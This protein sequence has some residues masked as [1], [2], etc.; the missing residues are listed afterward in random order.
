MTLCYFSYLLISEVPHTNC[1][2]CECGNLNTNSLPCECG[3][4]M[5]LQDSWWLV[6]SYCCTNLTCGYNLQTAGVSH[7]GGYTMNCVWWYAPQMAESRGA[8]HKHSTSC[9][10]TLTWHMKQ[11]NALHN[12]VTMHESCPVQR[13]GAK[14]LTEWALHHQGTVGGKWI[15]VCTHTQNLKGVV[16]VRRTCLHKRIGGFSY[17][18]YIYSFV[19][20]WCLDLRLYHCFQF[21][22]KK[23]LKGGLI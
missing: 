8:I 5:H 21:Q 19:F 6:Y 3:N 7:A 22:I 2:P 9:I 13:S 12:V 4:F 10:I 15:V 16:V 17:P 14:C 20:S 1:L 23:S 11:L 18:L